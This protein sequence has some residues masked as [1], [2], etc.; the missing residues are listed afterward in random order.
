MEQNFRNSLLVELFPACAAS[1]Y[2]DNKRIDHQG[3]CTYLIEI[4]KEAGTIILTSRPSSL[5]TTTKKNS[6][7]TLSVLS[8]QLTGKQ[9]LIL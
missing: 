4:A 3:I 8:T 9:P 6:L 5:T 7:Y 2:M 1:K